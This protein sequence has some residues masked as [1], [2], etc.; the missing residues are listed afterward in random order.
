M[1]LKRKHLL[2]L[3]LSPMLMISACQTSAG[4]SESTAGS[5]A[6]T[7]ETTTTTTEATTT[8]PPPPKPFYENVKL[9]G[10]T[11]ADME[12][13]VVW[14]ALSGSG[15]EFTITASYLS[16]TIYGDSAANSG[17]LDTQ[18]RIGI[19]LD[20]ERVVD[21]MID[22]AEKSFSIFEGEEPREATVSIV[23]LSEAAN[24]TFG[25]AGI[26]T[27]GEDTVAPTENKDLLIEFIGDSITCGYG[28]DDENRDHHF[29]TTTEDMTKTYAY[30]TAQALNA[31]Y[32]MVCYSG[33]G[34]IS[35][36]TGNGEKNETQTLPQHYGKVGFS[37]DTFGG[38][39]VSSLSWDFSARQPDVIVIN[40][41]T[42]DDSYCKYDNEKKQ[43]FTDNYVLFLKQVRERNP[44]AKILCAFGV[45]GDNMFKPTESAVE[46]YSAETGDEN[47]DLLHMKP[48]DGSTGYAADWHPT[49][50]THALTAADVTAKIKEMLG[51]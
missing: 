32:S 14:C 19:Y 6:A 35:G 23:K 40:L 45:Q 48:Q 44:D 12:N 47:I 7:A 38:V 27:D 5:T 31:D 41:G 10:R 2:T 28:V 24:S 46:A 50:A 43:D 37:Y 51:M 15:V 16:V 42:N 4:D 34:I 9:L 13:K 17:N 20:G 3:L 26:E 11:Y 22:A 30:K 33:Y 21:D 49:E 18:A 39:P 36:Y 8:A 29:S 25:I 1:K